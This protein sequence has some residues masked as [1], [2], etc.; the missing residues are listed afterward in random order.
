MTKYERKPGGHRRATDAQVLTILT[1]TDSAS[2]LAKEM[3]FATSTVCRIRNGVTK[4]HTQG[5]AGEEPKRLQLVPRH[6]DDQC[7]L[8]LPVGFR[9][10][11]ETDT[12]KAKE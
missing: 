2:K 10:Q 8:F 5:G 7:D 11:E 9:A 6:R 3:G 1:S 12:A 4:I